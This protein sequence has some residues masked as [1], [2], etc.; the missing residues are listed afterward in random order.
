MLVDQGKFSAAA[1]LVPT[2]TIPS[3]YAYYFATSQAKSV[4]LGL[5]S[6]VNSTARLSVSDSFEIVNGAPTPPRTRA[7]RVG[8]RPARFDKPGSQVSP[9]VVAED[10]F[11]PQF[12]QLIWGRFDPIPKSLESTLGSSR[13]KRSSMPATTRA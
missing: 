3:T 10:G 4:S 1:A 12:V 5:W 8:E 9:K 11:T 13:P 6:I 2:T 7:V